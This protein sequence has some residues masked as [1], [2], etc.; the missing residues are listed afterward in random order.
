VSRKGFIKVQRIDAVARETTIAEAE[1]IISELWDDMNNYKSD[2]SLYP[3]IFL[4]VGGRIMD[5]SSMP[6]KENI[7]NV[8][9]TELDEFLPTDRA[10]IIAAK[11]GL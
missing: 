8:I 6:S 9:A 4:C 2:M 7:T 3:D 11:N 5:Y 10:I 1:G